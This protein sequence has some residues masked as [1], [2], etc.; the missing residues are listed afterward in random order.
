MEVMGWQACAHTA[1]IHAAPKERSIHPYRCTDYPCSAPPTTGAITGVARDSEILWVESPLLV[2]AVIRPGHDPQSY[3][4]LNRCQYCHTFLRIPVGIIHRDPGT[5]RV[6][7][8]PDVQGP[9]FHRF[10]MVHQDNRGPMISLFQDLRKF[11]P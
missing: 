5:G 11:L 4:H 7:S 8:N 1:D 3:P 10:Q 9:Q 2:E 6:D